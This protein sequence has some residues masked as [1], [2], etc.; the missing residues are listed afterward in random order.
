M[1]MVNP[2]CPESAMRATAE[3]LRP[4]AIMSSLTTRMG[5]GSSNLRSRSLASVCRSR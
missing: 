3:R 4:N 1:A 2:I 5:A